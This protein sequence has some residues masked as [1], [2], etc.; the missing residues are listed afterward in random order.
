LDQKAA[1]RRAKCALILYEESYYEGA[2]IPRIEALYT[3]V[4]AQSR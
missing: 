2:L 1:L 3:R 4:I